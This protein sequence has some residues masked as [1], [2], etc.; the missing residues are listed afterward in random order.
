M[1]WEANVLERA[2]MSEA[3]MHTIDELFRMFLQLRTSVEWPQELVRLKAWI[4]KGA[5]N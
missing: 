5:G 2:G 4:A 1:A 3:L